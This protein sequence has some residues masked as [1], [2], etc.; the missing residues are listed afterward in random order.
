MDAEVVIAIVLRPDGRVLM[1]R[2]KHREGALRWSFPGGKINRCEAE[3]LASQR[4]VEEES[5][6]RCLPVRRIGQ[7][8]HPDTLRE[9]AYW[10]CRHTGGE[11]EVREPDKID[12]VEWLTPQQVRR[13]VR[14]R[15]FPKVLSA[16]TAFEP[17]ELQAALHPA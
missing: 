14:S 12:K 8:T 15:I 7:W 6:I 16:I 11:A 13:R 1:V 4:D 9:V 17:A 10:L 5:G 2:R 3:A